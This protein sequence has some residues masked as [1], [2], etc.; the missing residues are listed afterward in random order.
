M[1]FVAII[2]LAVLLFARIND[3]RRVW[4]PPLARAGPFS[5]RL[6]LPSPT[7]RAPSF[8]RPPW[9]RRCRPLRAVHGGG[10]GAEN[11]ALRPLAR[12]QFVGSLALAQQVGFC[13]RASLRCA[14]GMGQAADEAL[15]EAAKNGDEAALRDALGKGADVNCTAVGP[16]GVRPPKHALARTCSAARA[17]RALKPLRGAGRGRGVRRACAAAGELRQSRIEAAKREPIT[18]P[19]R[20]RRRAA[21]RCTMPQ[22]TITRPSARCWRSA[23]RT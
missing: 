23:E 14:A 20:R 22:S 6:S 16:R 5:T 3:C 10:G 17:A 19:R 7:T 15:L 11:R 18:Q 13:C 2:R 1:R 9:S 4:M 8:L 12:S 21:R